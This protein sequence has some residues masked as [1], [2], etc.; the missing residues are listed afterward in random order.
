MPTP[1]SAGGFHSL[2]Y[3][4]NMAKKL[5]TFKLLKAMLA[6][7]ACK[8]CALGMGGQKGGM[9]NESGSF[10]ELCKKSLQA[11]SSDMQAAMDT[12]A[13]TKIKMEQLLKLTPKQVEDMGRISSP[14]YKKKGEQN[15]TSIN[16]T[17]A[18]AKVTAKLEQ[19]AP[20]KSFFYFSGRSSNEAGFLLQL[21][22]RQYG[23]NHVNN[24]S[25]YCHQASGVGLTKSIGSSTATVNLDD[26]ENADLLFLIGGNPT[27]NHPRLL[28][29][30]MH[31]KRKGGKVI[32]INPVVEP[33][34][35]KFRIP[36]DLLSM[37]FGTKIADHY[38]QPSIGGDLALLTGIAKYIIEN[39]DDQLAINDY[40]IE[41]STLDFSAYQDHLMLQ[42][43]SEIEH[44]SGLSRMEIIDIAKIYRRSDKTIFAWTM[45]ITHQL[46]GVDSVQAI[47]N[48]ALLR[49][50]VGKQHAGLLPLRGHSNVQGMGTMGVTPK[51]KDLIFEKLTDLGIK[52]PTMTGYDT[53]S[54]MQAAHASEMDLGFCLGGNLYGSNPDL[55]YAHQALNNVG[56]MVY[57]NTTLNPGHFWGEGEETLILPVHARDEEAQKTT[58]ESMFSYL[59][60]SD[61]GK[62]RISNAKSEVDIIAKIG[63]TL[64]SDGPLNW[65]EMHIHQNI[66]KIISQ[67]I[68]AMQEMANIDRTLGEFTIPGRI[69]HSPQFPTAT[70]KASFAIFPL[71]N[72]RSKKLM[73]ISARSEGQYNT[74]VFEEN[75]AFRRIDRRDVILMNQVDICDLG[76]KNNQRVSVKSKVG[77]LN[78][79][80]I[81][82]FAIKEGCS[83]MY[84]PESNELVSR[85]LDPRSLTPAYKAT[86]I[87]IIA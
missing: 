6:K 43:W 60:L 52:V 75:D 66:R 4:Y 17:E 30:L 78:N 72:N 1:Q 16:W 86:A 83:L 85:D 54:C 71:P 68:P 77:V 80:L 33:G 22:A 42:S 49:G 11:M 24:C 3:T 50:M 41:N 76:L 14:L 35:V 70:K 15:F 61:G 46:H 58:Q 21:L 10:P 73:M 65:S 5:G 79:I 36:S 18:L 31:M 47:A 62:P 13:F 63:Q 23:T 7:N 40:F 67:T 26:V 39:N 19:T 38:I 53:M 29:S 9:T 59:R 37:L 55:K 82:P 69:L 57:L 56:M 45:G 25:Y 64:F 12:T 28:T 2:K 34:L 51:L 81:K 48:L 8:T 84:Y 87:E 74:V 44:S 27:S 32:V 20:D